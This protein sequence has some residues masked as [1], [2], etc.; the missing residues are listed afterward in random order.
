MNK[1]I[2]SFLNSNLHFRSKW[3]RSLFEHTVFLAFLLSVSCHPEPAQGANGDPVMLVKNG[4]PVLPVLMNGAILPLIQQESVIGAT[5][6]KT[7]RASLEESIKDLYDEKKSGHSEQRI[8]VGKLVEY[9]R[10]MSGAELQ[11]KAAKKGATG[12]YVGL[13]SDFPW[14][15]ID[16]KGFGPE[17]FII[18]SSG[19]N[20]YLLAATSLGVRAAVLSFLTDQGCRWFFPG[21]TWEVVPKKTT[22]TGAY[23]LR[24]KPSYD[25][26]RTL[27]YGFGYTA[28]TGRDYLD[29]FYNNRMGGP[30]PLRNGHSLY[31]IDPVSALKEHPEWIAM[32]NGKRQLPDNPVNT[33]FCYSNP[34]VVAQM[35]KHAMGEAQKGFRSITLAPADGLGFCECD[36]CKSTAQGGEIKPL[37]G[38]FFATRPD[39]VLINIVSETL[40]KAVNQVARAVREKYPDVIIGCYGYSAYSHPPSFKLE[41][42]IFLLTTTHYRRTPLTL[43]DQLAQWGQR[44]DIFGIRG[45]AGVFYWD[46]VLPYTGDLN[47]GQIQQDLRFYKKYNV[48]GLN[49]EAG[50]D[51][52]PRGLGYYIASRLLWDVDADVKAVV[53]DFY[54]KAFGPAA[55]VMERYYTRYYGPSAAVTQHA[56][57][58][59]SDTGV[60]GFV[61]TNEFADKDSHRGLVTRDM[62]LNMFRDLEE[63]SQLVK[64]A[65]AYKQRI[66]HLRMYAY[67]LL[68]R[69]KVQIADERKDKPAVVEA[70]KNLTQYIGRITN[71]S[72][73]HSYGL[74]ARTGFNWMVKPYAD[75][76]NGI[77]EFQEAEHYPDNNKGYRKIGAPPNE[78]ELEQL[79]KEGKKYLGI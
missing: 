78:E 26:G 72:M 38:T 65:P 64:K 62:L 2:L 73:I 16:L 67:Y 56:A 70:I 55:R 74:L 68:L 40:F 32:V 25:L 31:G 41:P 27:W 44:T 46:Y 15:A 12:I 17:E 53:S 7:F 11:V 20:L 36:L 66:D 34:E 76:I 24:Q 57:Q 54:E 59:S 39:G 69:E 49:T 23:D 71:T 4:K 14:L 77:P 43:E 60:P 63:A 8:A 51:W 3:P 9:I 37:H 33:K 58:Q 48:T 10:Q 1:K 79:W 42:N 19:K 6:G 29:W 35:T 28:E 5:P 61:P 47:P 52:G 50:N 45:Y 30:M 18:R 22:V 13:A 21:K 75:Y